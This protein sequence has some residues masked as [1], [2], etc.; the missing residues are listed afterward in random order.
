[1]IKLITFVSAASLALA[2]ATAFAQGAAKPGDTPA[3]PTQAAPPASTPAPAQAQDGKQ[4]KTKST[5][6]KKT[7]K[8]K[9]TQA[10]KAAPEGQ[11]PA[12]AK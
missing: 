7:K 3:A 1:M 11:A 2:T 9:S 6:T 8:P 5:K 4:G 12:T 10:P